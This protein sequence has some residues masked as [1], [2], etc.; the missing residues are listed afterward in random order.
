MLIPYN[1]ALRLDAMPFVLG[2]LLHRLD[3]TAVDASISLPP[4]GYILTLEDASTA[5]GAILRL[6]AAATNPASGASV[7][8]SALLPAGA[9][10]TMS[11]ETTAVLHGIMRAGTGVLY[12]QRVE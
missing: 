5:A 11:V 12:A 7:V 8:D 3:L 2:S 1:D 4:G 9:A 10:I 6:G